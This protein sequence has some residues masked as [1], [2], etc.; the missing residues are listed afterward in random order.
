MLN[1]NT[2]PERKEYMSGILRGMTSI[3][4]EFV[5]AVDGRKLSDEERCREFDDDNFEKVYDRFARPG[6]IGCTLSH[7]KCYRKIL[8][9]EENS[10]IIFEDDIIVNG[11]FTKLLPEIET[12][13]NTDEPRVLLLS[14]WFWHYKPH[15][16]FEEYQIAKTVDGLLT[17]A[18]S[19]NK[20]AARLM[21]DEQPW[22]LADSWE[23][24]RKRG[25]NI[26]GLKPHPFDQ[27][28]SGVFQTTVN[29]ESIKQN[30]SFSIHKLFR[31]SKSL[32]NKI[33]KKMVRFEH[34]QAIPTIKI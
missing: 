18:Y 6:E 5:E 34:P 19:I 29:N 10:V 15:R 30:R 12:W 2:S 8:K 23:M 14:G 3:D 21:L 32:R 22:Y 31:K 33:L 16:F 26:S 28:W 4:A 9:C 24:F 13:L 27:N 17:H 7:Q 25:I 1:L 20:A 11:E